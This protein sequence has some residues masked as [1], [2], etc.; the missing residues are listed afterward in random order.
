MASVNTKER[1]KFVIV[2][3]EKLPIGKL[4]SATG[5]IAMSLQ[6]KA[7]PEQGNNQHSS[8]SDEIHH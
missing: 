2:P 3:N 1:N 4:L 7:T 5:Q 8:K 6:Q